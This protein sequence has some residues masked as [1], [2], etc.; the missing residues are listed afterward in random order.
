MVAASALAGAAGAVI[1]SVDATNGYGELN[2]NNIG[3]S[4]IC[5]AGNSVCGGGAPAFSAITSAT[6]TTAAMVLGTGSSLTVSG[7]GTNNATSVGGITITGT[8]S[9]GY[10]PT[11]T[12]SSAATWQAAA[13]GYPAA[14]TVNIASGSPAIEADLTSCITSSYRDYEIRYSDYVS[15][16]S[17]QTLLIQFSGNNGSTYDTGSNYDWARY[18]YGITSNTSANTYG[19]NGAGIALSLSG[20]PATPSSESGRLTLSDPLSTV[21]NKNVMGLN[22]YYAGGVLYGQTTSGSYL[23]TTAVN[24]F[25]FYID[26]THTFS[27]KFTCQ[28]L[29]Q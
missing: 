1:Y 28:P 26:G 5:T 7:S 21:N 17:A 20:S 23:I 3:L 9:T 15:T 19:Q 29:P 10:V 16:T 12:S 25:R 22:H 24:A 2:E 18:D 6:N 13:G 11:A 4:R 8:P 14:V 27:G